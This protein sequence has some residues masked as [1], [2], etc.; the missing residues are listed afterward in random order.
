MK[1]TKEFYECSNCGYISPKGLGKCPECGEW[2]T[3]VK[4]VESYKDNERRRALPRYLHS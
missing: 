1:K 3:F 4:K 2:N